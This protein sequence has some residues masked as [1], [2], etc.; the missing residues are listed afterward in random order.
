MR[1]FNGNELFVYRVPA[2]EVFQD[3]P[4]GLD[5]TR[6]EK[7]AIDPNGPDF[8]GFL[9]RS[10]DGAVFANVIISDQDAARYINRN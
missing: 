3:T 6:A 7:L 4:R 9:E 2:S 5:W 1:D 8:P 10:D